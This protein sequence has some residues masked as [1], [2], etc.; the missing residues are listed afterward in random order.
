MCVSGEI[1]QLEHFSHFLN[2][3]LIC[4]W[5]C[6]LTHFSSL[7]ALSFSMKWRL[8]L[9]HFLHTRA[10]LSAQDV[11]SQMANYLNSKEM[12]SFRG[13]AAEGFFMFT[14]NGIPESVALTKDFSSFA[15]VVSHEKMTDRLEIVP[16]LL[17]PKFPIIF[18]QNKGVRWEVAQ[19]NDAEW[20]SEGSAHSVF[21]QHS[22][23]FVAL[24][25]A[26]PSLW[27]SFENSIFD[28]W[29][30]RISFGKRKLPRCH[31]G[32]SPFVPSAHLPKLIYS[33]FMFLSEM[34]MK[35]LHS[36]LSLTFG[37]IDQISKG[38]EGAEE[39]R[40]FSSIDEACLVS[41]AARGVY[42]NVPSEGTDDVEVVCDHLMGIL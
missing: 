40:G 32:V 2:R 23:S 14:R 37:M 25:L 38:K 39:K 17:P 26:P 41:V 31:C 11:L 36:D 8:S 10:N 34:K 29:R 13:S 33:D 6:D 30:Q 20:E 16:F 15:R 3:A 21:G 28:Y 22:N 19:I 42:A 35:T 9:S 1:Y 18:L 4:L 5:E 24:L 7:E 12:D 27:P